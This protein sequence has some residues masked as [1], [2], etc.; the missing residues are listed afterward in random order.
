M[1]IWIQ[2]DLPLTYMYAVLLTEEFSTQL[3]RINLGEIFREGEMQPDDLM[4]GTR[5]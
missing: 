2:G 4:E 5:Q 1:L 3:V